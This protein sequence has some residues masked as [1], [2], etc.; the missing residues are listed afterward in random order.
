MDR[1][2]RVHACYLHA[3][4]KHVQREPMTNTSLRKRFGIEQ[5]NS[6]QASRI[7]REAQDA[8]VI[9]P[10]DPEQGNRNARYLPFWA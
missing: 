3:C 1:E 4:L 5:H 9:K 2:E 10:Y 8:G 7:I 6:A